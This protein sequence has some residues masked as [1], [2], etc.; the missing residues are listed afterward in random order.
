MA[1]TRLSM[2]LKCYAT[3]SNTIC[4]ENTSGGE[5]ATSKASKQTGHTVTSGIIH[6]KLIKIKSNVRKVLSPAR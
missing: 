5:S 1:K 2:L 4:T 3:I 6:G